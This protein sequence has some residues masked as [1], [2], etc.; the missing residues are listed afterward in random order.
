MIRRRFS[1]GRAAGTALLLSLVAVAG[2]ALDVE[3]ATGDTAVVAPPPVAEKRGFSAIFF[4]DMMLERR[5]EEVIAESG[6]GWLFDGVRRLPDETPLESFDI[7]S[8]N[9]EGAVTEGGVHGAPVYPYDFA[10][11]PERV[12]VAIEA[13]FNY[14]TIA[15]NHLWDQGEEGVVSTRRVLDDLG[16]RFSGDVDTRVTDRSIISIDIDTTLVALIG[17]SGVYRALDGDAVR[18]LVTEAAA[19]SD[20]TIVNVHWGVEYEHLAHPSQR[21]LAQLLVESGADLVIGHHPHVVQGVDLI[22]GVPV[23]YSLGN[24]VFDQTFSEATQEG[25]AVRVH[26]TD[27][28]VEAELFPFRSV[29]Y[30]PRWR[31]GPDRAAALEQI[32]AW[33]FVEDEYRVQLREGRIAAAR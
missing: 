25:L 11:S 30:Q 19:R 32:A 16:V 28:L 31:T 6:A 5:L 29:G 9:L 17:L 12:A 13:G 18:R 4:G 21:A 3:G 8:A 10:F 24:F 2:A 23:F 26:A 15:N 14:F 20:F 1:A 27:E 22:D 33:S 7:A